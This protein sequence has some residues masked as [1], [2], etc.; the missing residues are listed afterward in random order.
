M[1]AQVSQGK[2]SAKDSVSQT[3]AQVKQIYAKW[4]A[5]GKI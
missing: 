2:L 3:N 4:K 5:A 1:F